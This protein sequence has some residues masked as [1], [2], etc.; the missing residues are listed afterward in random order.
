MFELDRLAQDE[1]RLREPVCLETV[2]PDRGGTA[3]R[4]S[5][6]RLAAC[7]NTC[8]RMLQSCSTVIVIP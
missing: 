7:C 5:F 6:D 1:L 4:L 2:S 8:T 3:Y